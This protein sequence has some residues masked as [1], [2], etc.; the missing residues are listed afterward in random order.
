V[1]D[2]QPSEAASFL[3]DKFSSGN[4]NDRFCDLDGQENVLFA[5][6]KSIVSD[7][8]RNA[9]LLHLNYR[10]TRTVMIQN[11]HG[12]TSND[13]KQDRNKI[14]P[15]SV[16]LSSRLPPGLP[17]KDE[18]LRRQVTVAPASLLVLRCASWEVPTCGLPLKHAL[19]P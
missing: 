6:K 14:G 10:D 18:V 19:C 7:R 15:P 5:A 3:P 16:L 8:A 4:E 13:S 17:G 1:S 12:I 11:A 9:P 2:E